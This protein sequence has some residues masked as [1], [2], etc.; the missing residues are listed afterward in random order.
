MHSGSSATVQPGIGA[1]RVTHFFSV[2]VEEHFHVNGFERWVPRDVWDTQPSRVA[3]GTERVLEMLGRHG[4][5]GT[6]FTLGLVADQNPQLVRQIAGLGHEVASHGHWHRRIPTL[7]R[8]E[9]RADVRRAKRTLEDCIGA[10][11]TGFRAP[12]FSLTPGH[13]WALEVL[14]EEGHQYD[15]SLFPIRRPGYGYPSALTVPHVISTPSGPITELPLATTSLAGLRLP[16]AGGGY[17]RQ[18]PLSL[19][20]RALRQHAESGVPAM[21]YIHPWELD[22]D[23]PRLPVSWL[24]KMRHYRNLERVAPRL[25]RLLEE[26]RFGSVHDWLGRGASIGPAV[27]LGASPVMVTA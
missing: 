15:S 18:L 6:F 13:E 4:V 12:S 20:Q 17:L 11:V 14:I 2:D 8:E 16:A 24:A 5:R 7:T 25:E 1:D 22:P 21:C 27:T 3:V 10:P 9:M 26:F 19:M 23:Q